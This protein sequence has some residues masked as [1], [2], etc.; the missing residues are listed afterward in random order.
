MK[1]YVWGAVGVVVII[2]LVVL[3]RGSKTE[4]PTSDTAQT[5]PAAS[6]A[7]TTADGLKITVVKQGSGSNAVNDDTVTVNYTG[8]LA[9]GTAFDS[10]VDPKFGHA[11][12]FSFQLGKG[13]VIK[14]W[15]EGVLG[16]KV[17]E[18]RILEIPASLGYGAAGY[19]PVPGNASLR[20][21]V[22][23]TAISHS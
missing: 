21:D 15:D 10:N 19:G 22:T 8:T 23:V 18:E 2:L 3:A 20:F 11:T 6:D 5:T 1:N 4:A 13:M 7:T 9:D 17:G 16:M 14:G 12:P